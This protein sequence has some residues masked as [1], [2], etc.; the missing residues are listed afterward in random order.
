MQTG[1]ALRDLNSFN[2]QA[3][4]AAPPPIAVDTDLDGYIANF[5][6]QST[7]SMIQEGLEQSRRDFDAFLEENVQMEWDA[8]RRRIYEHFGLVKPGEKLDTGSNGQS[9]NGTGAFGK[10]SRRG[11]VFGGSKSGA[12]FGASQS[13]IGSTRNRGFA[14]GSIN[15][16]PEK[17][18]RGASLPKDRF[19]RDKQEKFA[20]KVTQLNVSRLEWNVYPI[21]QNF[22][23]VEAQAGIDASGSTASG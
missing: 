15:E 11:K 14:S 20:D 21:L 5:H 18:G 10:S 7:L 8:Q 13:V 19:Q 2:A 3:S 1:S 22:A 12:A 17:G 4:A 16:S 23:E 6:A 9:T